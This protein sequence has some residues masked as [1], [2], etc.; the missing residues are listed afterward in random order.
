MNDATYPYRTFPAHGDPLNLNLED[1]HRKIKEKRPYI[2]AY[3]KRCIRDG[4]RFLQSD[5]FDKIAQMVGYDTE[6]VRRSFDLAQRAITLRSEVYSKDALEPK[7][8]G[9]KGPRRPKK[10]DPSAAPESVRNGRIKDTIKKYKSTTK[11]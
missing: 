6:F 11:H 3:K 8:P 10:D 9:P 7:K 1:Q 4:I 5:Q 2:S